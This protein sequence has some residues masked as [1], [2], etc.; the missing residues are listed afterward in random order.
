MPT[1]RGCIQP[2]KQSS[3]SDNCVARK[4]RT[5]AEVVGLPQQEGSP[6][7]RELFARPVCSTSSL[8][9]LHV[10]PSTRPPAIARDIAGCKRPSEAR[11]G[12]G[13]GVDTTRSGVGEESRP[14]SEECRCSPEPGRAFVDPTVR[15]SSHTVTQGG[16]VPRR[17]ARHQAHTGWP[18][19]TYEMQ[20]PSRCVSG[21]TVGAADG[22]ASSAHMTTPRDHWESRVVGGAT[23]NPS[24]SEEEAA[25]SQTFSNLRRQ[26]IR[27]ISNRSNPA[28]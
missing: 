20:A 13:L 8:E 21:D 7:I 25:W 26:V 16:S 6:A 1:P 4:K 9:R 5:Q 10:R 19:L 3:R 11:A 22:P 27:S 12:A 23:G 14:K 2:P 17:D 24:C 15:K 28:A 18:I